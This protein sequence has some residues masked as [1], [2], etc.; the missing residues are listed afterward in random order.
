MFFHQILQQLHNMQWK[1][2]KDEDSL[3]RPS[4]SQVQFFQWHKDLMKAE[5]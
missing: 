3:C 2:M 5:D 1:N 4:L